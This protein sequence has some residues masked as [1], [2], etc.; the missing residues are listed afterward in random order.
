MAA[1]PAKSLTA[2]MAPYTSNFTASLANNVLNV[3]AMTS[4]T[5]H[6]VVIRAAATGTLI[7]CQ[8]KGT[9]GCLYVV[10]SSQ[11]IASILR[12]ATISN[13]LTVPASISGTLEVGMTINN[14][15]GLSG[16]LTRLSKYS[17]SSESV[18]K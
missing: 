12:T 16:S 14:I 10:S 15:G 3:T 7:Q 13:Q 17:P 2:S 9:S 4:E 11:T 5:I 1:N 18:F 8:I 6:S